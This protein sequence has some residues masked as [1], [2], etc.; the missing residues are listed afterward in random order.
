MT[1]HTIATRLTANGRPSAAATFSRV[2]RPYVAMAATWTI[3]P[4]GMPRGR[5]PMRK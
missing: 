3:G 4:L 2:F 5:P 1:E